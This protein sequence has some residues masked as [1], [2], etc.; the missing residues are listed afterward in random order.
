MLL[1]WLPREKCPEGAEYWAQLLT[2]GEPWLANKLC[3]L[4]PM[5]C[6]M[7]CFDVR[8][9]GVLLW[10]RAV[11]ALN[12]LSLALMWN[13]LVGIICTRCDLENEG[14]KGYWYWEE[15]P[16]CTTRRSTQKRMY[17]IIDKWPFCGFEFGVKFGGPESGLIVRWK[18]YEIW[19]YEGNIL[20]WWLCLPLRGLCII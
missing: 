12:S 17:L 6:T 11:T 5:P 7:V 8:T 1:L 14:T 4:G 15:I 2:A 20:K 19:K 18:I 10:G 16:L 13:I 9:H 3:I